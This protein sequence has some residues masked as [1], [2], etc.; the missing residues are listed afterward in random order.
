MLQRRVLGGLRFVG[1]SV[2]C[3]LA[4]L[5]LLMIQALIHSA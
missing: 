1:R 5:C 3:C 4:Y 2:A